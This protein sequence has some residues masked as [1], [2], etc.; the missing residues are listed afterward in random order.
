MSEKMRERQRVEG[1]NKRQKEKG[2]KR[3]TEK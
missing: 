1:G 3:E 2:G